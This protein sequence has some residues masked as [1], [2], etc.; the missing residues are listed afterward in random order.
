MDEGSEAQR[1]SVTCLRLPSNYMAQATF[2]LEPD[3]DSTAPYS[4]PNLPD[5]QALLWHLLNIQIPRPC[6]RFIESESLGS[7]QSVCWQGPGNL[8]VC[9]ACPS[10]SQ[11]ILITRHVW[12]L[13]HSKEEF[14]WSREIF[15]EH[16]PSFVFLTTVIYQSR[17]GLKL[18]KMR[19]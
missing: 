16:L 3:S 12:S 2:A 17:V 9:L 8:S 13:L 15:A 19:K 7:R 10:P 18:V 1:S 4:S 6:P 5:H 14:T 11:V